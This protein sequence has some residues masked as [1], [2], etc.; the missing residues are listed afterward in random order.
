MIIFPLALL[1]AQA[2]VRTLYRKFAMSNRSTNIEIRAESALKS[3][4]IC[5][6]DTRSMSDIDL[7]RLQ[8][9]GPASLKYVRT[10]MKNAVKTG[11]PRK[12]DATQIRTDDG[13]LDQTALGK[14]W[15]ISPRTLE[16]WRWLKTGPSYTKVGSAVRYRLALIEEWE[17]NLSKNGDA[18]KTTERTNE[19][20]RLLA[21]LPKSDF[22]GHVIAVADTVY[23][24]KAWFEGYGV[25]FTAADLLTMT[26]LI[27]DEKVPPLEGRKHARKNTD[28]YQAEIDPL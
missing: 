25:A 6:N 16:R 13:W 17:R 9:F 15:G 28:R 4:G 19:F 20:E 27:L 24:C 3:A 1:I 18:T 11:R 23:F 10:A 8:N 12:Q 21:G 7:L 22:Q 2:Y 14:R 5:L 26:K